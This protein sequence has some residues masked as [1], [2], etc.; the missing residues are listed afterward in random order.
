MELR[1]EKPGKPLSGLKDEGG[2]KSCFP[3]LRYSGLIKRGGIEQCLVLAVRFNLY[4]RRKG[5]RE[6]T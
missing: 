6:M 5:G 3:R 1:A 4:G 2:H